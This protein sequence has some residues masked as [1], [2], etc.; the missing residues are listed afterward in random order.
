[1][2]DNDSMEAERE[3]QAQ[4]EH[5]IE[6]QAE[7]GGQAQEPTA[8]EEDALGR[9]VRELSELRALVEARQT[10][11]EEPTEPPWQPTLTDEFRTLYPALAE[12]DIPDAVWDEVRGGLPLA[13]AYALW[14]RREQVRR[15]TAEQ[16]NRKN[17]SGA[18]GRAD[19]AAE[20]FLSPDEVRSMSPREVRENYA[21]IMESM[22]HWS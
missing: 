12:S 20:D 18:W 13:A 2:Q 7:E 4:E 1:M 6:S 9:L 8:V 16:V 10:E 5:P 11:R 15:S 17:A 3:V 22:K 19:T 21:R 14:E